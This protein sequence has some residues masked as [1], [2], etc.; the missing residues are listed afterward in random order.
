MPTHLVG[1]SPPRDHPSTRQLN[2]LAGRAPARKLHQ[3]ACS[4]AIGG[5]TDSREQSRP[6]DRQ[7]L[8]AIRTKRLDRYIQL[9]FD[10]VGVEIDETVH[11]VLD[12]DAPLRGS[13]ADARQLV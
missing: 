9:P 6:Y 10:T 12:L 8:S 1:R 5:D 13:L 3:P 2:A 4:A 7:R 11:S